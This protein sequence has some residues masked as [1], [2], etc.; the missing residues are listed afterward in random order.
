MF[1][2]AIA[3]AARDGLLRSLLGTASVAVGS[4]AQLL[5]VANQH[6]QPLSIVNLQP[7]QFN[8]SGKRLAKLRIPASIGRF[9]SC[10]AVLPVTRVCTRA[11]SQTQT[12]E[13]EAHLM[14]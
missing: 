2:I 12:V 6:F 9:P 1:R 10:S 4:R 5:V 14:R 7:V 8:E 3:I 11:T 13:R